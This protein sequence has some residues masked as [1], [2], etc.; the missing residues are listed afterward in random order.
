MKAWATRFR[1]AALRPG[2]GAMCAGRAASS[3][4]PNW[5]ASAE[6]SRT[7]A[8]RGPGGAL[9]AA[10][11]SV[12]AKREPTPTVLSTEIAPPISATSSLQIASPRP[13]PP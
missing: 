5:R 1:C 9:P 13:V 2:S 11:G 4:R 12:K 8:S 10:S 6:S 3:T 7:L